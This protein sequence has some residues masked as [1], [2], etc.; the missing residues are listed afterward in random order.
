MMYDTII[1]GYGYL[2]RRPGVSII[3]PKTDRFQN[4][5][6]CSSSKSRGYIE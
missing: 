4:T 1:T 6:T 2:A 5:N 3:L